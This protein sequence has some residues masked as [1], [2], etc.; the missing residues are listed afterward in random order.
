MA[1]RT[2]NTQGDHYFLSLSSGRL[3]HV[4]LD[5]IPSQDEPSDANVDSALS[6]DDDE[7]HSS[8]ITTNSDTNDTTTASLTPS[9]LMAAVTGFYYILHFLTDQPTSA[10]LRLT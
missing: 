9:P 7:I 3:M 6:Q 10:L 5:D 1:D 8:T 2:N 4:N